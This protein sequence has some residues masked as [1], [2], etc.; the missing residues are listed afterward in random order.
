MRKCR[1]ACGHRAFVR[2]YQAERH[3]QE[4]VAEHAS[5]GYETEYAA[6][7]A[8]QPLVTFKDWLIQHAAPSDPD[9]T[10]TPT[11][12]DWEPPPGF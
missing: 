9:D 10:I 3:R 5:I 4:L 12:D 1:A 8:D 11:P 2:H 7:V 6:F